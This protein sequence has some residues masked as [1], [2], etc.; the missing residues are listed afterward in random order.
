MSQLNK[1]P[2]SGNWQGQAAGV[3][4]R[5]SACRYKLML[6]VVIRRVPTL[7]ES[8]LLYGKTRDVSTRGL[9]FTTYQRLAPGTRIDLSLHFLTGGSHV[10][11]NAQAKVLRVQKEREDSVEL[12]GVGALI[13]K[14][15]VTRAELRTA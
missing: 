4:E 11:I 7:T 14:Y 15:G 1:P 12:F 8:D 13:E 10:F 2:A 3:R 9:Y 5:R 6:H